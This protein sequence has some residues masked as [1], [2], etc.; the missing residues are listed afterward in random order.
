MARTPADDRASTSPPRSPSTRSPRRARRPGRDRAGERPR[1]PR[2]RRATAARIAAAATLACALE[3]C[4]EKVGN[5]TPTRGFA[6]ARFDDFALS[7]QALG[8]AVAAASAGAGRAGRCTGRSPPPRAWRPSNTNLGMALLF[9]PLAAAARARRG[10]GPQASARPRAARTQ[11]R[12]R[13]LGVPGDPAR[14]PGRARAERRGSGRPAPAVDHAARGHAAGGAAA[15]P[16]RRSTSAASRSRSTWRWPA[17]AR[18]LGRGLVAAR[19]HRAGP[20]RADGPGAGHADRAQG[21]RRGCGRGGRAGRRGGAGGRARDAEGARR[22]AAARP[23]PPA[24]RQPAQPRDVGGPRSPPRSSSGSWRRRRAAPAAATR[25]RMSAL[26]GADREGLHGLLRRALHHLR[27]A[28]VRAAPRPQLPGGGRRSRARS[29]RTSYVFDF[30]RLKRALRAVVDRLDHRMLLPTKSAL[31]RVTQSGAEVAGDVPGQALR[32]P[33]ERRGAP[34]HLQHHR[35]DAG[36]VDRAGAPAGPGDASPPAPRR[37]RSR[38]TSRPASGPSTARRSARKAPRVNE[39]EAPVTSP[40]VVYLG[41]GSNLGDRQANLAEALQSLRAPRPDRAG[42]AG[43][44]DRAGARDRPAPLPEPGGEG[45]HALEPAGAPGRRQADRGPDGPAPRRAVRPAAHRHRHPLLRTTAWSAPTRSRCRT[46]ASPSAASSWCRSTTSRR[47]SGTRSL[48]RT[49]A[50]LLARPRRDARHRPGGAGPD[51]DASSATCRRKSP[52][53]RLRLDQTGVT[54]LHRIIRLADGG[55]L[56]YATLDLFVELP[57]D[58]KGAHMSRFSD[59]VEEVLE[60]LGAFEAPDDRDAGRAHRPGP[61]RGAPGR[62]RGRRDPRPVPAR[63]GAR[64]SPGSRRRSS[65]R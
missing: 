8:A 24:A 18:A 41:L 21:R 11:R 13:A 22:R 27:R 12:R 39:P 55:G 20:S 26:P 32:V 58:Q 37:S 23:G 4:A 29:T 64:P 43:L 59:T 34:A 42:L 56:F 51:G 35:G 45:R 38:W 15:T 54:G 65:T 31:I 47:T 36:V 25:R 48:G 46:R 60:D 6:D 52:S 33:R 17:S 1:R 19:R 50:E 57:A 16:W 53:A 3:A 63:R 7:A 14:P 30:T 40:A 49:V 2:P 44:R 9:A 5:V 62:A 61:H 10:S 28:R